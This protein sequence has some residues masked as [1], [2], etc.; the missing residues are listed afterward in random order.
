VAKLSRR[1]TPSS[2]SECPNSR[3]SRIARIIVIV[4]IMGMLG[5]LIL[6]PPIARRFWYRPIPQ[7]H[8]IL[9]PHWSW[10]PGPEWYKLEEG[11]WQAVGWW[12]PGNMFG[13]GF[14]VALY[15]G[16]GP[17]ES[18]AAEHFILMNW[19]RLEPWTM[20]GPEPAD[21]LADLS[22]AAIEAGGTGSSRW[23]RLRF[24]DYK[25]LDSGYRSYLR[26]DADLATIAPPPDAPTGVPP[27]TF[28]S[29]RLAKLGWRLEKHT[30]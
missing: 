28:H 29:E 22:V 23:A 25:F 2:A 18:L 19:S 4:S 21:L 12:I 17:V 7:N 5:T 16:A 9:V 13:R 6:A 10:W 11:E 24:C 30:W 15:E 14:I 27:A 1:T 26:F 3:R 20:A 8:H